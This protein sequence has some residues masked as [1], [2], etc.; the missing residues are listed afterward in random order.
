MKSFALNIIILLLAGIAFYGM[1][2]GGFDALSSMRPFSKSWGTS[3]RSVSGEYADNTLENFL[4]DV[5]GSKGNVS[6]FQD[7]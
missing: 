6:S 1:H 5:T 2:T 3:V 7:I 4:A